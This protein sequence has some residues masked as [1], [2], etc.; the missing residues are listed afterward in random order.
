M[1]SY[2]LIKLLIEKIEGCGTPDKPIT[3]GILTEI[4]KDAKMEIDKNGL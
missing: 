4:L 1:E 2:L 3:I